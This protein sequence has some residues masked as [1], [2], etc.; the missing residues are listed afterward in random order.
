MDT[1]QRGDSICIDYVAS[2]EKN[3]LTCLL[4]DVYYRHT[5]ARL[6]TVW[7]GTRK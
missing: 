4:D 5:E 2:I 1:P 7:D 3:M 6:A